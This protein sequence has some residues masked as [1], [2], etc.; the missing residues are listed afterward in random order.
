MQYLRSPKDVDFHSLYL[1]VN[2]PRLAPDLDDLSGYEDAGPLFD[3]AKQLKL[4]ESI[5]NGNNAIKDLIDAIL[6]QGWMA[7]DAIVVYQPPGN[8]GKYVVVEGN[9]RLTALRK[10]VNVMLLNLPS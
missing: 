3:D 8:P 9:R 5:V 7:I 4:Q 2:N 10:F 6:G 1:D